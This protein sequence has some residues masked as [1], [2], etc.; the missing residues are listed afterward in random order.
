[1]PSTKL[2]HFFDLKCLYLLDGAR[3]DNVGIQ[4]NSM[5]SPD[6]KRVGYPTRFATRKHPLPRNEPARNRRS[7]WTIATEPYREAH[8]A[9]YPTAVVEPC[10]K[11]GTSERGCCANCGAPWRRLVTK[12][13]VHPTDYSGKWRKSAAQARGRWM[14]ASVRARREAGE[15]H[16]H[17][18]PPPKTLGWRPSCAHGEDVVPCTVLDPFCGSGTCCVSARPLH[19]YRIE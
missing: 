11:A 8:F 15:A 9:T 10:I 12:T 17:P 6:R 1:M 16:D 7:V 14:L 3:P 4:Y 19:R 2:V 5:R 13:S 18:F